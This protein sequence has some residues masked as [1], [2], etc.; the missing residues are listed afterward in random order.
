MKSIVATCFSMSTV[1]FVSEET[2]KSCK[3]N[4][5]LFFLDFLKSQQGKTNI[6]HSKSKKHFFHEAMPIL[7]DS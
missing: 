1:H 4:V 7:K 5:Q 6:F 3:L 2:E